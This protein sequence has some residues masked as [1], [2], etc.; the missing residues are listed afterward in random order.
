MQVDFRLKMIMILIVSSS[1]LSNSIPFQ[2]YDYRISQYLIPI[3]ISI[4]PFPISSPLSTE[5]QYRVGT[6]HA[7]KFEN[8]S[9]DSVVDAFGISSYDDPKQALNEMMRVLKPGGEEKRALNEM[10]RV[11]KPGGEGIN[12]IHE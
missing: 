8:D 6:V 7:M 12:R 2:W 3:M 5:S 10:M 9:F 11:L 4:L 1:I